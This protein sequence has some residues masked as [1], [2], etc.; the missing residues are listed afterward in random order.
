MASA[1]RGVDSNDDYGEIPQN[2]TFHRRAESLSCDA[3]GRKALS[4]L[5]DQN[6]RVYVRTNEDG[7][8]LI[9]LSVH[10]SKGA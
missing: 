1:M 4:V 6:R 9:G 7:P 5:F 8:I 2:G 10:L 3:G